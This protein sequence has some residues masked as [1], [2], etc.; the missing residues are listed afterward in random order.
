MGTGWKP[1]KWWDYLDAAS[2]AMV[3]FCGGVVIGFV[4]GLMA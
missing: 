2:G 4:L 3:G 1:P